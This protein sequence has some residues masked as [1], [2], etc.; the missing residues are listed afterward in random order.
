MPFF[1]GRYEPVAF[2]TFAA[3]RRKIHLPYG[4]ETAVL[5]SAGAEEITIVNY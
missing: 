5:E 3:K 2:C 1:T 4:A